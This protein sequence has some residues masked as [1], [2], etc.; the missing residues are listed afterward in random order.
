MGANIGQTSPVLSSH[1]EIRDRPNVPSFC[2]SLSHPRRFGR[3]CGDSRNVPH[4]QRAEPPSTFGKLAAAE[5]LALRLVRL[6]VGAQDGI[7]AGLIAAFAAEPAQQ[8]GIEAHGDRFFWRGQHYLGRF[9]ECSVCGVRVAISGYPFTD[10]SRCTAAQARPV[11]P[12][13][14]FRRCALCPGSIALRHVHQWLN[15]LMLFQY[16]RLSCG[17]ERHAEMILRS[18]GRNRS[19]HRPL[20]LVANRVAPPNRLPQPSCFSRLGTLRPRSTDLLKLRPEVFHS[21]YFQIVTYN[22]Y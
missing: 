22:L 13:A 4:F 9:P 1:S 18:S 7:D 17:S 20:S 2:A 12:A 19:T 8:V 16:S 10:R 21:K 6:H 5:L 15:L 3:K 11:G 14:D